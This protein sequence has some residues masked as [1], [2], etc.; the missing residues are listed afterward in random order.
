MV[1]FTP[2]NLTILK[3]LIGVCLLLIVVFS[4]VSRY[5]SEKLE[6]VITREIKDLVTTATDSLY[7]VNFSKVK[8]NIFTGNA[9]M[10]DVEIIP[11]TLVL[12]HLTAK[13]E[14][15][16]NIYTIRL[17]KLSIRGFHPIMLFKEKKLHVD[18][19]L[20][21][22]PSIIMSNRQLRF[23]EDRLP[24]SRL[25]PYA[26]ISRYLAELS[27]KTIRFKD[28]R[29]KYVNHN[30]ASPI[31]DSLVNLN[32]TL[33]DWLIDSTSS[34]DPKRMYLLKD[35]LVNVKDY[36]YATPDSMYHLRINQLD[37]RASTGQVRINQFALVPRYSE[38]DF[39]KVLGYAKD[40]YN[41]SLNNI[42]LSGINFPAYINKQEL[43]A[44]EMKINNG[45]VA[46]FNN[47]MLSERNQAKLGKFPHQLL[48]SVKGLVT[49]KRLSLENI[50]ISYAEYDRDSQERGVITFDNT[51]GTFSNVTNSP[52]FKRKNPFMLAKLHSRFMNQGNLN[53]N[54]KFDLQ[55]P[56][57]AFAYSG[58]L[59]DMD[60][61]AL[62]KLTRPLGMLQIKSGYVNQLSFN[63]KANDQLATGK[64]DFRYERLAVN[65]LKREE[66]ASRLVKK[67]WLSFLANNLIINTSNPDRDGKHVY[68]DINYRKVSNN[69]F[70]SYMYKTL[71]QGIKYSIGFTSAKEEEIKTQVEK[72]EKMKNDRELRRENRRKRQL[73]KGIR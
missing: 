4:I 23:N 5:Y 10:F 7:Q 69:S 17:K 64:L 67:G 30:F 15:P 33:K 20:F 9:S 32:I 68:A 46:V 6:P 56:D 3:W 1:I 14:A 48:Q 29:F 41:V 52:A 8:T 63:I 39:G 18:Q 31:T 61:K 42:T 62:N 12:K 24:N 38:M 72:F 55:A 16:N 65:I 22:N 2:K 28:A 58:T 26:Y 66:G 27:V 57:G 53:L 54:F 49:V 47:N 36:A 60:G 11:D 40:R 35:I 71:F 45:F 73:R 37:F 70:F 43:L 13:G 34:A 19:L 59:R 21:D 44:G 50:N 25:S 51:S